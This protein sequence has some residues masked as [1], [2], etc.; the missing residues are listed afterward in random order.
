MWSFHIC[1]SV[2]IWEW[3]CLRNSIEAS[4][5]LRNL[6]WFGKIWSFKSECVGLSSKLKAKI[7]DFT[8]QCLLE[9]DDLI[10]GLIGKIES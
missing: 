6:I 5:E 7:L 3:R 4:L 2:R 1:V 9:Q 8:F 10:S